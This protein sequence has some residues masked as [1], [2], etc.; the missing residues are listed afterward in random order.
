[1]AKG[2]RTFSANGPPCERARYYTV[3]PGDTFYLVA[4][5]IGVTVDELT[6]LNP[7]TDPDNLQ[8]GALICV[9]LEAGIPTGRVPPCDSGL[10]WVIA[11]GDTMFSIAQSVGAPLETLLALNPTADPDNLRPGDSVCLPP[12]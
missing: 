7:T 1:M 12:R 4:K 10:Y 3:R 2:E 9:P 8:V 11:P 5:E 6:R